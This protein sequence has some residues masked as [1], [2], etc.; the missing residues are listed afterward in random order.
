[1]Y[2]DNYLL[3]VSE[4]STIPID[5]LVDLFYTHLS[6]IEIAACSQV[7]KYFATVFRRLK[8]RRAYCHGNFVLDYYT[9]IGMFTTR[10]LETTLDAGH[11]ALCRW[12]MTAYSVRSDI[13]LLVKLAEMGDSETVSRILS[14]NNFSGYHVPVKQ[15][16]LSPQM[17]DAIVQ[18][19]HPWKNSMTYTVCRNLLIDGDRCDE[20]K[21]IGTTMEQT[22]IIR[23]VQCRALSIV[24]YVLL[25]HRALFHEVWV[26]R[27]EIADTLYYTSVE[28]LDLLDEYGFFTVDPM[29]RSV[30]IADF[31]V[32][33]SSYCWLQ[34]HCRRMIS[35]KS[36]MLYCRALIH[37]REFDILKRTLPQATW[38]VSDIIDFVLELRDLAA[39]KTVCAI[40]LEAKRTITFTYHHIRELL[41][42]V[43]LFEWVMAN[44]LKPDQLKLFF[45]VTD[46][47][48]V[49][50]PEAY[51]YLLNLGLQLDAPTLGDLLRHYHGLP[52]ID[53]ILV[54]LWNN[55][56]GYGLEK[57][58]ED[59]YDLAGGWLIKKGFV[60]KDKIPKPTPR[61]EHLVFTDENYEDH[62]Y[63]LYLNGD[64]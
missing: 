2:H 60:E 55:R 9:P 35:P 23:A 37:A 46:F 31:P 16:R 30:S 63:G 59:N 42:S 45:N 57:Q 14:T 20:L 54:R 39:L 17:V 49:Y 36:S 6:N 29:R 13:G 24:T 33:P 8:G 44:G 48:A 51:L 21:S 3:T 25:D 62:L 32:D 43:K 11:V 12:I 61:A 58:W 56:E 10:Q 52:D 7:C 15:R 53:E 27:N 50:P 1:M 18:S 47:F 41:K 40:L 64:A 28:I 22:D 19:A 34:S 38:E 4:M 5:V 26:R